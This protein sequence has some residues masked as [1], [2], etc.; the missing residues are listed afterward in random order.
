MRK[1]QETKN[2]SQEPRAKS[3]RCRLRREFSLPGCSLLQV[4]QLPGLVE[5]RFLRTVEAEECEPLLP[6]RSVDPV[7][8]LSGRRYRSEIDIYRAVRILL[9]FLVR[10]DF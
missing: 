6:G 2:K 7:G 10:I 1:S 5:H 3:P 4:R 9:R 8:F